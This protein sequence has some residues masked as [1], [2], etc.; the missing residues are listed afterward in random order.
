[1]SDVDINQRY[2]EPEKTSLQLK[3][4]EEVGELSPKEAA[5]IILTHF[6]GEPKGEEKL[7]KYH[8]LLEGKIS[9][10]FREI[11]IFFLVESGLFD[12][13]SETEMSLSSL[14]DNKL[15]LQ[16]NFEELEELVLASL[17]HRE[18]V[19]P[20]GE[21]SF[22]G[23]GKE[24]NG[25]GISSIAYSIYKMSA[26]RI[27][28]HGYDEKS[29]EPFKLKVI[30]MLEKEILERL[31]TQIQLIFENLINERISMVLGKEIS[32][33]VNEEDLEGISL[34]L[35]SLQEDFQPR[36]VEAIKFRER[37]NKKIQKN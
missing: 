36:L 11:L 1:M 6:L 29:E 37:K 10:E 22:L 26:E 9:A 4:S 8:R 7:N 30:Q 2:L 12:S 3:D 15:L 35:K 27:Q 24:I 16:I 20:V 31:K 17:E 28:F 23:E 18:N 33:T 25:F 34:N 13:S 32:L 19:N 5:E 21:Y 14:K